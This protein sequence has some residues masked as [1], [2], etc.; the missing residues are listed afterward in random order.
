MKN[1][2][3]TSQEPQKPAQQSYKL[4]IR[5]PSGAEFEAEGPAEFIL[6]EKEGFLSA[7]NSQPA[8]AQA[9]MAENQAE[10]PDW[11]ALAEMRNGL[12]ILKNK[13]PQLKCPEAALIIMA[14]ER[15]LAGTQEV[16]AISLSKAVKASGYAPERLDRVLTKAMREGLIKASGAKRNRYYYITDRGLERAWLDARKLQ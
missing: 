10:K 2:E 7:L 1:Q 12:T 9:K 4:R 16:S 6:K 8:P 5:H 13:H 15:Q 11:S 3:E 14:A